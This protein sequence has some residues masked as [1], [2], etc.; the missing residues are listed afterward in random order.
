MKKLSRL[1]LFLTVP[2]C[3]HAQDLQRAEKAFN[4]NN[5][6]EAKKQYEVV[7]KSATGTDKYQ[8]QLRYAACLYQLGENLNAAKFLI[9][10]PLPQEN[11]WKARFLLYRIQIAAG[12]NN[13]YYRGKTLEKREIDDEEARQDPEKWTS[14][15]WQQFIGNDYKTLWAMRDFLLERPLEQEKIIINTKNTDLRRI[16]TLFDFTTN[17]YLNWLNNENA[18]QA[19]PRT[20]NPYSDFEEHSKSVGTAKADI[21][22][23]AY[24]AGG[25]NRQNA[26]T[27]WQTSYILLPFETP[28]FTFS[29]KE[30]ALNR[31]LDELNV[32]SGF[33]SNTSWWER[34]KNYV[35]AL[36]DNQYARSYTAY[37]TAQLLQQNKR[38][39]GA[40]EVCNFAQTLAF[41][42]FTNECKQIIR[43]ITQPAFSLDP[44]DNNKLTP[45]KSEIPFSSVNI[46]T[47][48]FRLY[49]TSRNELEQWHKDRSYYYQGSNAVSFLLQEDIQ[50]I[51]KN[52]KD[53]QSFSQNLTYKKPY[54]GEN[55]TF[56]LPA[57]ANGLY[58]LL[59]SHDKDFNTSLSPVEATIVN[60]TDLA[61]F[62]TAALE[63]SPAD[64]IS[65]ITA[66]NKKKNV[67]LFR[68]YTLNRQTGQLQPATLEIISRDN[69][70]K[71]KTQGIYS[72]SVE[73]D[74]LSR[75]SSSS[76]ALGTFGKN[77][78]YTQ[79]LSFSHSPDSPVKLS[80]QT[81]RAIY[82]PGQKVMLSVN[83]L[84]RTVTGYN[85]WPNTRIHLTVK[86]TNYKTVFE[87][88]VTTNA[89]GTAQTQFTLPS[90]SR[91]L[92][93]YTISVTADQKF[94]FLGDH[95]F[96]VE[97]YK[98]PDYE[99]SLTGTEKPLEYNKE[100]T[101]KGHAQYYV[102]APLQHATVKYTVERL[103]Y[104][105]P[106]YWWWFEDWQETSQIVA[107]GETKTDTKGDFN[108]SFTPKTAKRDE[109][110]A[111]YQ[112]TAQVFDESGRAIDDTASY[113]VSL[114][115]HLFQIT[116]L[117]GFYDA[118]KPFDLALLNLTDV[119]GEGITGKL[120]VQISQLKEPE[121]KE[122]PFRSFT[123]GNFGMLTAVRDLHLYYKDA[124]DK[125]TILQK[126]MS[127]QKPGD[128]VL[129]L[130]A[131]EEGVYRLK[132]TNE[133]AAAQEVV[134]VVVNDGKTL[135]LPTITL[136]QSDDYYVGETAR[137]LLGN[138]HLKGAKYVELYQQN[139]DFLVH[140]KISKEGVSVFEYTV[141]EENRGGI[142]LGWFGTSDYVFYN[143]Q[144]SFDVPFDNKQLTIA[145]DIP[146][147][148]AP[149]SSNTFKLTVKDKSG[150]AVNG[151]AS[152]TVYD[153]SL[154][155]YAQKT[156]PFNFETLYPQ[157]ANF[158][159]SCNSNVTSNF[160]KISDIKYK[161]NHVSPLP[162]PTLNLLM[163][164]NAW[165]TQTKGRSAMMK[166]V[167]SID[168]VEMASFSGARDMV[169]SI[170][171]Q[172]AKESAAFGVE[173]GET[174]LYRKVAP[175]AAEPPVAVRSDFAETAYFNTTLPVKDGK[176]SAK[177]TFPDTLTTWNVLGFV[178]TPK[179]SFGD[180]T[181]NTV[182]RKDW[183]VRLVLPRF[184]RE[185]DSGVF[186]AAVTN[187]TDKRITVPVTL[188]VTRNNQSALKDFGIT[189]KEK[190]VTVEPNGT[191]YVEWKMKTPTRPEVYKLTASARLNGKS[192]GEQKDFL[193]LPAK[194]R[195]LAT[196]NKSLKEGNTTLE[197]TE[198]KNNATAEP[199]TAALNLHPSLALSVLNSMPNLI[200]SPYNDLVSSLNRYVPLAVVNQ[201]YTTYPELK[202]AV[203]KLPKR[204]GLTPSWDE[205][206][207]LRLTLLEQTPWLYQAE[208]RQQ[209]T[210][211][212]INLFD[213]NIVKQRLEKEMKNILKFQNSSGAFT[214]IEGGKDDEY[215]TLYA[216]ESFSE[217]LHYDAQIPQNEAK[218][219]FSYIIPKI[220]KALEQEKEGS[221]YT[222]SFALYAA[223]TLSS[224]P[225]EWKE[226]AKAKAHIKAWADYADEHNKLMT[227]LGQIY[228]AAVYHRLGD[229]VK[230]NDYLD[231]VLSR[232][233]ENELTGAYFAPEPQSWVWYQ[234]TL[235]TQTVTL[236]TLLAV[237]PNSDKVDSML[238]WLLFNRQANEW[239]SSKEAAQAVFTVLDVMKTKGA[240]SAPSSYQI[241]WAGE[242]KSL[243]FE[244]FDW[245]E[246]LQFVK[247]GSA[248]TPAAYTATVTKQGKV[249]D[250]ASLSVL[251]RATQATDSP[252]GVLNVTRE[253]FVRVKENNEEK[254]RPVKKLSEVKV[255]D[256]VEVHLTLTT[257]SAFEYV[258][259]ED[260][261][262][263][264][265]ES[266]DL[267]SGWTWGNLYYYKEI[268]DA[269]TRFFINRLPA[270]KVTLRYVLR[271]TLEGDFNVLPAQV[272]SMY[273]P[274][275][276]A[277]TANNTFKVIK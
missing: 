107:Q 177:V 133:K 236:R 218:K 51:L 230:A 228:A 76:S 110:F 120:K 16:P 7:L 208:G 194:M 268:K 269:Q 272:Q 34:I 9:S 153:K 240:L 122:D 231:K 95:S 8:A 247:Q 143:G 103:P 237:R 224:F 191:S 225:Q 211:D 149:A 212:I 263:A 254:L 56:R 203:Q 186:Q 123:T 35:S 50:F 145:L 100:G 47:L 49:P 39:E 38:L 104:Y 220:N 170:S 128:Q 105:P 53:F 109:Q 253:Y 77:I 106:F 140:R 42:S 199:E 3:L 52:K 24:T 245:T 78:A 209:Q 44:L 29:D 65:T 178:L 244:P 175:A 187:M 32:L 152:L 94:T 158:P 179:V 273:A 108:I 136:A 92:G 155:Y 154:D 159:N 204:T 200:S 195:L 276:G 198:V 277:H 61:I 250:F 234:D 4:D 74:T 114:N 271:P 171:N 242:Q 139:G 113:V 134:F 157:G 264:A 27:F 214:W 266:E 256:E 259:L 64:Y 43:Q 33:K 151:Q 147:T 17:S 54:T 221:V 192:D 31:A 229:D 213:E 129:A 48:Y 210:A 30:K 144:T 127:F 163:R 69:Q 41:S 274:E 118:G 165:G 176:A 180:F 96:R 156:N 91:L 12:A 93:R 18:P 55:F 66:K 5:F 135:Q 219:A 160:S 248:I 182:S 88:H 193:V 132:V 87:T 226:F 246:D 81:D 10:T 75:I 2:C 90:D 168:A 21:L 19:T 243:N 84:Q 130:P 26:K 185:G 167:Q 83:A 115:P 116:L 101:V 89:M 22:Y 251:Y 233:K 188:S 142:S 183:M 73:V 202:T 141:T 260:P 148:V 37:R 217:A 57:Q 190:T 173:E 223:Y 86:D 72:Q 146:Q 249:T 262:P 252:K 70:I 126:E 82:R 222:V 121:K 206:D 138:P 111:K 137:I 235:S 227:A 119:N 20:V 207:P 189:D 13:R 172:N 166:S 68:Y 257:D 270:G 117:K 23:T 162:L 131:L 267:L 169:G 205:K 15:Q 6:G 238:K 125:K 60:I 261:K 58:V 258:L 164:I 40:L 265:F 36:V 99:I 197:V 112:V 97:E 275:F 184:Y 241:Q 232:M 28:Y 67:N 11:E 102:G 45:Q 161:G 1:F 150:K 80:I 79:N 71:T 25:E 14:K 59:A 201:F 124:K 181:A 216:L 62:A 255:G 239:H 174:V 196:V 98:R 63:D 85:V 46:G 215:L